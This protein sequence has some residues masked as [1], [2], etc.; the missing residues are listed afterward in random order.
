MGESPP[1]APAH[2]GVFFIAGRIG[3]AVVTPARALR[4]G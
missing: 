3:V 4:G 2:A 1:Q